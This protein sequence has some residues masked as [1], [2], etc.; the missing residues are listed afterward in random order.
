MIGIDTPETTYSYGNHPECYGE[1][2]SKKTDSLPVAASENWVE[3]EP[4]CLLCVAGHLSEA[5]ACS[6][7]DLREAF[8]LA[9]TAE[10]QFGY[11]SDERRAYVKAIEAKALAMLIERLPAVER[12]AQLLL[13]EL[14]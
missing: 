5:H 14:E 8:E 3:V 1:E 11:V 7:V 4:W 9:W 2:A 13:S 10:E 12:V 6:L